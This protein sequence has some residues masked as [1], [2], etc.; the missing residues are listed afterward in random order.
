MCCV[1]CECALSS[2]QLQWFE[3]GHIDDMVGED[4]SVA[5]VIIPY[6]ALVMCV[7][8]LVCVRVSVCVC[9]CVCVCAC[10]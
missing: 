3:Q 1:W 9:V 5:F 10:M 8:M 4:E 2:T 6:T 7:C